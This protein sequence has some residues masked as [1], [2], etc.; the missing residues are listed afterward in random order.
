MALSDC[1]ALCRGLRKFVLGALHLLVVMSLNELAKSR[2]SAVL[3][4]HD[5]AL[6]LV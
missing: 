2:N 4:P 1:A 5:D 3:G 6:L